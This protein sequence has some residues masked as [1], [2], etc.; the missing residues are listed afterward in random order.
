MGGKRRKKNHKESNTRGRGDLV[1]GPPSCFSV[2]RRGGK[3]GADRA[4][5][6]GSSEEYLM[7]ATLHTCSPTEDAKNVLEYSHSETD[8]DWALGIGLLSGDLTENEE[9]RQVE[10]SLYL[11][12]MSGVLRTSLL[13]KRRNLGSMRY[14]RVEGVF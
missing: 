9:Q 14:A 8:S 6:R 12:E 7:E 2:T 10:I 5:K 1:N 13:G 3:A 11:A 4:N